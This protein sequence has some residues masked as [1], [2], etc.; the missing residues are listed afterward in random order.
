VVEREKKNA[1]FA[2]LFQT[3]IKLVPLVCLSLEM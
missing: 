3:K 1:T 2:L